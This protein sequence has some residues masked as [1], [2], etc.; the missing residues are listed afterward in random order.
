MKIDWRS[1]FKNLLKQ[2]VEKG[3]L[4]DERVREVLGEMPLERIFGEEQLKRFVLHD[5]PALIYFKDPENVRT[6]SAPHM[7]SMMTSMMELSKNDR[8]LILGSKGGVIEGVIANIVKD[9]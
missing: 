4:R 3:Y 1:T 8:V 7:I 9:V 5:S 2:H 6:C